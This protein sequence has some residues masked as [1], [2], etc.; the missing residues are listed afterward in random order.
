MTKAAPSLNLPHGSET[1]EFAGVLAKTSGDILGSS[2]REVATIL[3]ELDRR[4]PLRARLEEIGYA[5]ETAW[6]LNLQVVDRL[7]L[8]AVRA[9]VP[10]PR[11]EA[12]ARPLPARKARS[13]VM[14]ALVVESDSGLRNLMGEVIRKQGYRVLEA[15]TAEE[16]ESV[17]AKTPYAVDTLVTEVLISGAS[18]VALGSRLRLLQPHMGIVYTVCEAHE[19]VVPRG[20]MGEARVLRKPFTVAGLSGALKGAEAE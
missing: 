12:G 19:A 10:G 7:G 18:G 3:R 9:R 11:W 6:E 4:H 5:L 20:A 17:V 16:A 14:V 15:G 1:A 8:A 2:C 13:Q